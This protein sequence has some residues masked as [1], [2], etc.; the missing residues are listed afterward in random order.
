MASPV[1]SG[2]IRTA[3]G[4]LL[5]LAELKAK[6]KKP[7]KELDLKNKIGVQRRP[8]PQTP[9]AQGFIPDTST[10]AKPPEFNSI[11]DKVEESIYDENTTLA[12]ITG[13]IID[14]TTSQKNPHSINASEALAE[15]TSDL[16]AG[17]RKNIKK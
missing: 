7:I 3:K 8:G 15:I 16:S 2:F 4:K 12:D 14:K 10:V 6:A 9:T 1:P 11:I 5:N 17:R 13:V